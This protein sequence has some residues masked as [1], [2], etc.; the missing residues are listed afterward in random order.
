LLEHPAE[1]LLGDAQDVEQI[2][3]LEP[4]SGGRM[5][6]PVMGDG[7]AEGFELMSAS[8]TKSR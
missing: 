3:D 1:R 4:D 6:H 7:E 5:H 2:G 8:P